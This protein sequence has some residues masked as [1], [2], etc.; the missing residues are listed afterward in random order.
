MAFYSPTVDGI[1]VELFV[2]FDDVKA[3]APSGEL[4]TKIASKLATAEVEVA[5]KADKLQGLLSDVE[6]KISIKPVDLVKEGH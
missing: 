2:I 5:A 1:P 6:G 4:A 3:I